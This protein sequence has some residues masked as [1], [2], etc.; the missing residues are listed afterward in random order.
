M[1]EDFFLFSSPHVFSDHTWS[2]FQSPAAPAGEAATCLLSVPNAQPRG[3]SGKCCWSRG[4][5][6][7]PATVALNVDQ[8]MSHTSRACLVMQNTARQ[9]G[10]KKCKDCLVG[11]SMAIGSQR[12]RVCPGTPLAPE[13]PV[14]KEIL[15][16]G[17]KP[18]QH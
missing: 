8:Q 14:F 6:I 11:L 9:A 7:S 12:F 10:P 18:L 17:L 5:R 3:S 1:M 13:V 16:D 2:T 4:Y 15:T